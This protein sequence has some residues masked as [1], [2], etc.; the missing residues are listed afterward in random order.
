VRPGA[1]ILSL[2]LLTGCA[3]LID[4]AADQ[5]TEDLEQAVRSYPEP[6]VVAQGLPAYLLLLEARLQSRPQDAATRLAAAR[7]TTSY[8]VLFVDEQDPEGGRRLH[9]HALEQARLGACLSSGRLCDLH[10]LSPEDFQVRR[11]RFGHEQLDA[12]YIL[13]TSWTAWLAAHA[14]DFTALA[15]LPRVESLLDWVAERSPGQDDGA[16]WLYLAVL[17]SQ[18]HP[19]AGGQPGRSREYFERARAVSEGRN[20]LVNVLMAEFHARP[21]FDRELYER[22]LEEVLDAPDEDNTFRLVNQIARQRARV[23]LDRSDAWFD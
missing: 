15:D 2:L 22:L 7:L 16:I 5:F 13:A 14:E 23:K 4:R 12:I 10:R 21:N 11:E 6:L 19:A 18:R 20:L 1:A 8:A 3:G 9:R 17:H